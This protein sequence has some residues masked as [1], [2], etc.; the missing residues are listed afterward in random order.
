MR[1]RKAGKTLWAWLCCLA[2][3]ATNQLFAEQEPPKRTGLWVTQK[4]SESAANPDGFEAAVRG[5]PHL[6]GV[7]LTA[8]WK[9]IETEPGKLDFSSIDKTVAVLHRIGMKYELALK[10][11][12]DT[13]A[14]VFRQGAQ[15]LQTSVANPHRPNFGEAVSVP[16][17][18]DP[19]YQ[20][21]FSRVIAQLGER[22]AADPLCV[23]VVLTCANFMS[24]EMHLPKTPA[25]RAKWQELGDYETKL[26][27]VYKKYTDEWAKAFPKQQI[28]LHLSQVLD[29]PS[30]FFER[31]IDYG[32]S[33]YPKQFTIQNCQLTGRRED[34][35]RMSYD[36]VL[37][38]RDRLH[39]GFQSL[40]GFSRGGERMGSIQMAVLNVVHADGEYWELWHGDGLSAETSGEVAKAWEEA[41]GLGYDAYKKKLVAEGR[42]QEQS[43]GPHRG[44]G[45]RGRHDAVLTPDL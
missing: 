37:K 32:L 1:R 30:T 36:L 18:W 23:G 33:K 14:Y 26:V 38:Y 24:K 25:D 10:P 5:N 45:R 31:I 34:T 12:I 21:N 16:V 11:G 28:S 20:R 44:R 42:Y 17:P 19:M 6:A 4:I 40:A 2:I 35:G 22:Y 13:P 39:H 9:E 15:S 7:C 3:A 43:R 8:G 41:K 29:L 27:D